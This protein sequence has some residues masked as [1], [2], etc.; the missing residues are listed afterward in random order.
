MSNPVNRDVEADFLSAYLAEYKS[1]KAAGLHDR[2]E[3]V[4]A[5]LRGLGHEVAPRSP[6]APEGVKER[7]VVVEP[8]ER[9]VEADAPPPKRGPGRPPKAV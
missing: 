8:L 2:A 3:A 9:A 4:A 5:V 6:K 1:Y 7:A